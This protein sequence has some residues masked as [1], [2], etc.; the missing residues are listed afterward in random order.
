MQKSFQENELELSRFGNFLLRQRLVHE[1]RAK[2]YVHWVRKFLGE[3]PEDPRISVDERIQSFLD[4]MR[5]SGR[6]EDWQAEQAQQALRLYF[7]NFKNEKDWTASQAPK[8]APTRDGVVAKADV[9][10]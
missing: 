10:G 2:F 4:A 8:V 6:Y 5:S 7:H 3:A 9:C 1:K